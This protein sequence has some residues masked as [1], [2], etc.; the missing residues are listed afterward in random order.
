[1]LALLILLGALA[2]RYPDY[3]KLAEGEI[4]ALGLHSMWFGSLGGVIVS[5]KG[6]Y[7]VRDVVSKWA[8]SYL[9]IGPAMRQQECLER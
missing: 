6:I 8:A 7:D 9:L 5:L 2:I 3:F 1:V 4:Y